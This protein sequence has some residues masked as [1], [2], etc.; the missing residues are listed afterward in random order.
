MSYLKVNK[1][2]WDAVPA[3]DIQHITLHL[4]ECGVLKVGQIIIA[5]ADT[6]PPA[7]C[8]S[9]NKK[10]DRKIENVEAL[11]ID[12][13]CKAICNSTET[14]HLCSLSDKP[15]SVCLSKVSASRKAFYLELSEELV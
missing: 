2:V 10:A 13:L 7:I 1:R 15:L 4:Q 11:G 5:D 8:L 14:A 6:P 3:S 12:W 9:I